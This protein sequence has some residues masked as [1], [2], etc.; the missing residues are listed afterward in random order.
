MSWR[1]SSTVGSRPGFSYSLTALKPTSGLLRLDGNELGDRV[2]PSLSGHRQRLVVT[3][4]PDV[5]EDARVRVRLEARL[6]V[7]EVV[8]ELGGKGVA[9]VGE[10]QWGEHAGG[11]EHGR[12]RGI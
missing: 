9:A 6:D 1:T 11:G 5:V 4:D 2:E 3:E 10:Q 8:L 12:P 7:E